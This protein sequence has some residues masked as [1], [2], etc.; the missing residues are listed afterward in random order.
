[1]SKILPALLLALSSLP[2]SALQLSLPQLPDH[3][4]VHNPALAAARLRIAEAR[5]RLLQSGR[6]ANPEAGLEF[7]HDDRFREGGL[8]VSLDQKFPLTARLQ[9]E[10]ELSSK[11]VTAAELEVRE[12]ARK[13]EIQAQSLAVK[14]LALE[15]QRSLRSQQAELAQKLSE[16]ATQRAE[17]GELS[18]LDAAQAQLDAQR[19][20]LEGRQLEVERT[21]L[22]GELKP[23]LGLAPAEELKLRGDLPDPAPLPAPRGWQQRPDF[24]LAKLK[25]EAA[26]VE[27]DLAK[28][29]KWED[30]TAGAFIEGERMEDAPDGL[31]RT[32]FF[33][34]RVSVPLPFWN[35]N[36]GKVQEKRA[37]A[38]RAQLEIQALV[39][40]I[41]NELAAARADMEAQMKLAADTREKLLPLVQQHTERLEKAYEQG[42]ADLLTVLRAR[43][44]R[45]QLEA[46]VLNALRDYHLARVR[47]QAALGGLRHP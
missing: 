4:R 24:Q 18:P 17:V 16:F 23:L 43:D 47:Y 29:G 42:Q 36:E 7:K 38:R 21:S 25:A 6:F 3:L 8:G 12:E 31:E 32:P 10:K 35:N 40:L 19:M 9:L 20:Q 45:L 5:G 11:E 41:E 2:L 28:A 13:L 44:Q 15:R 30:L 33:G 14:L 1:M 26:G 22:L 46:A 27:I 34:I 39:N 37:A